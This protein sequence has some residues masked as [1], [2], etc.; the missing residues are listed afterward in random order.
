MTLQSGSEETDV[1]PY[2]QAQVE[3]GKF[4]FIGGLRFSSVEVEATNRYSISFR[5]ADGVRDNDFRDRYTQLATE[6]HR[7]ENW[8]PRILVNYRL[9]DQT[10]IRAGYFSTIARPEIRQLSQFSSISVDLRSRYGPDGN[11]PRVLY[12]VGN[13]ELKPAE[14]HNFDVS[15]E[16]FLGNVGVY[17]IGLFYKEIENPFDVTVDQPDGLPEGVRLPDDP[18]VNDLPANTFYEGFRP[19]N[20]DQ[21]GFI[22]GVEVAVEQP[23][24]FVSKRLADFSVYANVTHTQ[25]EIDQP[26]VW[27]RSPVYNGN[28]EIVGFES[29]DLIIE[30]REFQS[31]PEWSGTFGL[32]YTS[33]RLDG[34]L[35]Y[36]WQDRTLPRGFTA[37]GLSSYVEDAD[38]LDGRLSYRFDNWGPIAGFVYLEGINLLK[39][40]NDPD[41][42]EG[43]G[44]ANGV[45]TFFTVGRYLGGRSF[46]VGFTAEF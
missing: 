11:Q 18:L 32:T 36:T 24:D 27:Q 28:L 44:G 13:P 29:R 4:Q 26:F 25:S 20:N 37:G 1:A 31:S 41:S 15:F 35:Y 33:E 9:D 8:L 34:S 7:Q 21:N 39:G 5:D 45:P 19:I 12:N 43:I 2:F 42:E 14:T 30:D 46:R 38:T 40:R 17:K 23:L 10:I 22:W 3:I 16:R 6:S